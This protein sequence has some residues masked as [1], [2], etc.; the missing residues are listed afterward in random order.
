LVGRQPKSAG[1]VAEEDRRVWVRFPADLETTYQPAGNAVRLA[2]RVRDVSIGGLSLEV[3]RC[4]DP[5]DL[6]S[7]E[8]PGATEQSRTTVLA[9]VVHVTPRADSGWV[10]GCT[11]AR[12]LNAE[13]LA[14]SGARRERHG[15]SDQRMWVRCSGDVKATIQPVP[16]A[17]STPS[18]AQVLDISASGVGLRVAQ[19]I[20]NGALLS[21]EL[22]GANGAFKR[23]ML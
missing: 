20:E 14:A 16:T 3:D 7:V 11:F 10:L 6:L 18:P 17:N 8:L 21:V 13:D 22:Q 19:P 12:E 1:S 15:A 9:C 4:F 23:T 2:A 5:G